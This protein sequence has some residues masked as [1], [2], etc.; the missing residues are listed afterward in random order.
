MRRNIVIIAALALFA[1]ACSSDKK[2]KLQGLIQERDKLNAQIEQLEKELGSSDSIKQRITNVKLTEIAPSSFI[3]YIEIQGKVEGEDNIEVSPQASGLVTKVFVKEGDAVRKGQVMAE[4]DVQVIKQSIEEV[5]TQ[6]S[7]AN[8]LFEKQKYLWEKN[9]GSEVQYL[10]AKNG[11]ESLEKRLA[12]LNE[13][14]ALSRFV[15][16][17]NGTV[18]DVPV[19]VGQLVSPGMPGSAIRVVNMANVKITADLSEAYAS[20]IKKGNSVEVT[21]PDNGESIS[22]SVTFASRFI[23]PVNRTFRVECSLPNSGNRELRANMVASVRIND[24]TN[25]KA[26]VIPQNVIQKELKG[27]FVWIAEQDGNN[28]RVERRSIVAGTDYNGNTE[29]TSGLAEGDKVVTVG[30][31]GLKEGDLINF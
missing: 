13:Q 11:K 3:H 2:A 19:K 8:T 7:L 12:T 4:L 15:S 24:Y 9:I 1:V 22:A 16:P 27:N 20:K 10:Q 31:Q 6:L 30:Y 14:V 28:W 17:I 26:F 18:E 29:I 25:P 21:F 5:K 23:D